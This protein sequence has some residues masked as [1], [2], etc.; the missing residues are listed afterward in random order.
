LAWPEPV[1]EDVS[2][3]LDLVVFPWLSSWPSGDVV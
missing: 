3:D 1:I 2:A